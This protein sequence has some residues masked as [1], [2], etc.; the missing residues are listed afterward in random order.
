MRIV[1]ALLLAAGCATAPVVR[2]EA[3]CPWPGE[4]LAVPME[5]GQAANEEGVFLPLP[6]AGRMA[7]LDTCCREAL[8]RCDQAQA[9]ASWWWA[10]A[11][12]VALGVAGGA[13][14]TATVLGR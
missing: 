7:C 4:A 3:V 5:K 9:P 13:Y 14:V 6:L 8:A 10:L 2:P 1:L 12:G 11:G